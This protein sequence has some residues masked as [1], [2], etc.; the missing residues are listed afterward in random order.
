[1]GCS[2]MVR[3]G[4]LIDE[5]NVLNSNNT[6]RQ[7]K[8]VS[9]FKEFRDTNAKVNKNEL[10]DYKIVPPQHIAYVQTTKNEKCFA[11][12]IN[13]TDETYVV[14]SVNRVIYSKDINI[15][16][17][18]FLFLFLNRKEF[19]RYAIFNSWGSAREIFQ[20]AD[21][22]N[23]K[24][25]LPPIAFQRHLV[26]IYKGLTSVIEHNEALL[27]PIFDA[28]RA[29]VIDC[30]AKYTFVRLGE[31]IELSD[32][33]N[34]EGVYGVDDVAGISI[35]KRIIPTKAN[36]EGVSLLNYK[37]L[38]PNA[39]C[40]VTVT[41][42]NGEK[43]SIALN[44]TSNT[45]ITSSSYIVFNV[46][47][48]SVLLPEFLFLLYRRP[49]FDRYARF[50]SW[51]SARETFDWDEMLRLEIPLPPIEVQRSIVS[52]YHC[53]YEAQ[54]LIADAKEQLKQLCPALVQL[55][56]HYNEKTE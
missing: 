19:D 31:L 48:S 35:L 32:E 30:K 49:E 17:I 7:V 16:D 27:M 1:M 53:A 22:L 50:N 13:N 44:N 45:Y 43:I 11:C 29:F 47:D 26:G 37:V 8:S 41:S 39:F 55:A 5:Y 46:K 20:Y 12:A 56:I 6:I 18:N 21:L 38:N 25:P 24:I 40:Y 9:V 42:R 15:L 28:C 52:L 4:E 34:L 10:S 3:L 51:G 36:L 54:R 2:K 14:T 33:R 23:V